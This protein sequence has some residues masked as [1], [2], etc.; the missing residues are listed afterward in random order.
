MKKLIACLSLLAAIITARGMDAPY[1]DSVEVRCGKLD[2]RLGASTFWNMNRVI[3]DE[4]PVSVDLKGAYWG[5]V[6]EFPEIGFIGSGH[7][8][9]GLSE[10][11]IEIKMFSDGKYIYPEDVAK[12]EK[13]Q[14]AEFKM[15]KQAQIKDI[16][17]NYSLIIKDDRITEICTL[18]ALKASPL[19][20]M[21]NFMHPW[22]EEM[23]DYYIQVRD[24]ESKQGVF[25]TD[26]KFP[27]EGKFIWVAL[28]NASNNAGVVSKCTGDEALLFLWDRKQYKKTYMC[29]FLR[30]T[31]NDG[32][33]TYYKMITDFF[34]SP[35]SDWIK[36]AKDTVNKI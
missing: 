29:S 18:K 24:G 9:K 11:V 8:D 16:V 17:F 22:S 14:C 25:K 28:Y 19:K 7:K 35:S 4:L 2:V 34:K 6:F 13:I 33:E 3:Y 1:P 21:Y 10:K 12:S 20:L 30:K 32:Q 26:N 36:T 31:M 15:E 5:T 23:T 27:H